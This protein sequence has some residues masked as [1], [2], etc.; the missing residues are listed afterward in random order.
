MTKIEAYKIVGYAVYEMLGL[1]YTY[2]GCEQTNDQTIPHVDTHI[3][4]KRNATQSLVIEK[5]ERVRV[6]Y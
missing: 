2:N 3:G 1:S 6:D 5:L 4:E